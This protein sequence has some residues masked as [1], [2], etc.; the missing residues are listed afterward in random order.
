MEKDSFYKFNHECQKMPEG[1]SFFQIKGSNSTQ[2]MFERYTSRVGA[3]VT[4]LYNFNFCP[5]C[6]ARVK[7]DTD[8]D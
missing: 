5:Y 1:V 7:E 8:A 3:N 4:T 6:G 2:F